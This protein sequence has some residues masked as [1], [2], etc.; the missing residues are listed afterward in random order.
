MP[1]TTAPWEI[2]THHRNYSIV[3]DDG[4]E[5]GQLVASVENV[6][7]EDLTAM[8]AAPVMLAALEA[9]EAWMVNRDVPYEVV[10]KVRLALHQARNPSAKAAAGA[11]AGRR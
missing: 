4:S 11:K 8:N 10:S 1:L 6:S 9:V 2:L 3:H 7:I 5:D